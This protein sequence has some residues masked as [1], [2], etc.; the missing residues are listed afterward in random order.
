MNWG[1]YVVVHFISL[2]SKSI[3]PSH[4]TRSYHRGRGRKLEERREV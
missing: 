2:D 1:R 4:E 3:R